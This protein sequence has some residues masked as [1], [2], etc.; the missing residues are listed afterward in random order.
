[1]TYL[2]L[3]YDPSNSLYSLF[4][5]PLNHIVSERKSHTITIFLL[6]N[7][8]FRVVDF[9]YEFMKN[10]LVLISYACHML[11]DYASLLIGLHT[12]YTSRHIPI[13]KKF[14]YDYGRFELLSRYLNVVFLIVI[15]SL[16]V[17]KS[18]ERIL[19]P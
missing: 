18:I 5:N 10:L 2:I 16:I 7:T 9:I 3:E 19:D 17:L 12:S 1:M 6:I 4:K 14:N 8:F 11:F 13:N 15:G